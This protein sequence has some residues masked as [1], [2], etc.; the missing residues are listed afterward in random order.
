MY[1]EMNSIGMEDFKEKLYK[2]G[3]LL[4]SFSAN[5]LKN[6]QTKKKFIRF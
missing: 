4:I 2:L 1:N 3:A 6:H 5:H